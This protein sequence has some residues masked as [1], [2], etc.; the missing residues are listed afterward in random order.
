MNRPSEFVMVFTIW[1]RTLFF[2]RGLRS[3]L[4][5]NQ[6]KKMGKNKTE[7][8]IVLELCSK[9]LAWELKKDVTVIDIYVAYQAYLLTKLPFKE[10]VEAALLA[11]K[12]LNLK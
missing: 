2:R 4:K 3:E 7:N 1:L 12:E 8:E 11:R 5:I 9:M 6:K 10:C